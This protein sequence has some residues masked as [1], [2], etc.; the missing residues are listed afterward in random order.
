MA[1]QEGI[2]KLKGKIGD[3]S[4]YKPKQ[5]YQARM[6]GAINAKRVA[7]DPAFQRTRE[8]VTEFGVAVRAAKYLRNVLRKLLAQHMDSG[9]SNRLRSRMLRVVKA[10]TTHSRGQRRVLG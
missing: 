4:F 6:K 9:M 3:L 10:D 5:R 8:N 1:Q 2:I 7:T